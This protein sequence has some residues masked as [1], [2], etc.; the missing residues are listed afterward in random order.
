MSAYKQFKRTQ[1]QYSNI[2][3]ESPKLPSKQGRS[4]YAGKPFQ[5]L[6]GTLAGTKLARQGE[7]Q[8][9]LR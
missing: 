5:R 2:T 1:K 8:D 7:T 9:S 4:Y 6:S 3:T